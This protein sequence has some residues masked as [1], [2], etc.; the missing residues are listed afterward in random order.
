[1]LPTSPIPELRV[2]ELDEATEPL[3][4][5]FFEDNPLFFQA[6][7]GEPPQEGEA[8]QEIFDELPPGWSYTKKWVI[9]YLNDQ[10]RMVAMANVVSD[11]NALNVWLLGTFIVATEWHGS[12]KALALYTGLEQW[13]MSHGATWLRLGVVVGHERAERFWARRGYAEI[14][15]REG[16][17]M[18]KRINA[19]RVMVK[20]LY[21]QE[22]KEYSELM[23]RGRP[24]TPNAA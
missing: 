11:A 9:G 6:V 20:S 12:G 19:L 23:A 10:G 24:N 7:H 8:H 1:M 14:A 16:V 13:A 4:Q 18:G 22:L 5:Q 2:I 21:G 17:A 15:R 3:L